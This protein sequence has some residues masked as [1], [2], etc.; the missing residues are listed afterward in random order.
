[1]GTITAG[2]SRCQKVFVTCGVIDLSAIQSYHGDSSHYSCLSWVSQELGRDSDS[3]VSFPKTFPGKK[4]SASRIQDPLITSQHFT[5]E[6]HR[7]PYIVNIDL[8]AFA[9][10]IHL[11]D[12]AHFMQSSLRPDDNNLLVTSYRSLLSR[13]LQ[14]CGL[15]I[16]SFG[17]C[18]IATLFPM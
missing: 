18:H 3:D 13:S 11:C 16:Y 17:F 2:F 1:M 10:S 14:I 4:K 9:I 6:P 8:Y 15:T 12:L 7:P 5:T